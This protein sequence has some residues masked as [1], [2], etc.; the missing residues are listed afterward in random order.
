MDR[1]SLRAS[2]L[3]GEGKGE[4]DTK[5]KNQNDRLKCKNYFLSCMVLKISGEFKRGAA[6]LI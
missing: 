6:P 5:I 4:G 3:T 1:G 2:P